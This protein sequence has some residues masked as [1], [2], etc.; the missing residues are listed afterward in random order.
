[1]ENTEKWLMLVLCV[2]DH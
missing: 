2:W 1:M